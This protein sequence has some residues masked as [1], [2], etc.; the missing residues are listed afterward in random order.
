MKPTIAYAGLILCLL[1]A[2]CHRGN[3]H[4]TLR[5]NI[6]TAP[7]PHVLAVYEPWFGDP[8]HIDVGYSSQ[9]RVVLRSQVEKAKDLGVTAFVIDWYGTRKKFLDG[10]YAAMQQVAGENDFKVILMYDEPEDLAQ[11]ATEYALASLEYAYDRYIGPKARDRNAYFTYEGRPVVFIWPRHRSTD[12]DRI[13]RYL[14][15]WETPP[16]L[17]ME[18]GFPH[19]SGMFDGYFAWV[20]PGKEG[21][22]P[23]GS[24]RGLDYLDGF[25]RRMRKEHPN[26][27]VVG[28]AWPGFDDHRASWGQG[29]YMDARCGKTFDDT[30]RLFRRYHDHSNP[31][32][33]LLVIT[34]NDY[35]E[36]TAIEPGVSRCNGRPALHNINTD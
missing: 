25:Y 24:N 13:H 6:A 21:W 1:L 31:L 35:E 18:D 23:D 12:W 29:R 32:P 27:I 7:S 36:G 9:D 33:F 4:T 19:H 2:G 14:D 16:L 11:Q 20:Q 26:K 28:A 5:K 8:D 22:K 15:T 34:W 30:L 17:I 10:A 3:M